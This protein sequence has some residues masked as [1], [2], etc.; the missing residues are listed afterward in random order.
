[1]NGMPFTVLTRRKPRRKSCGSFSVLPTS[2]KRRDAMEIR[3]LTEEDAGVLWELRLR[4]LE[5]EPTA[6]GESVEEHRRFGI[7]GYRERLRHTEENFV[8]GAWDG[9]ALTG[10]VGF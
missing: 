10:M 1:S 3:R 7:S 5:S 8:L 2:S 4:A 6:F 9:P